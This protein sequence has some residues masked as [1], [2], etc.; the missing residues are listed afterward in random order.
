MESQKSKLKFEY[1][2]EFGN[3]TKTEEEFDMANVMETGGNPFDH[4]VDRFKAFMLYA[5]YPEVLVKS[6]KTNE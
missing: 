4:L 2:D 6:I 3:V 1:T 5:G